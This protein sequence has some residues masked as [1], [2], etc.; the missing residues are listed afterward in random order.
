MKNNFAYL[1][2]DGEILNVIERLGFIEPT[3][4]QKKAI[5]YIF[6]GKDVVVTAATGSGK[7]LPY[8]IQ[9][10][11]K[12]VKGDGLQGLVLVPTREL[13]RQVGD[14]L[15]VFA[16]HKKLN[17]M[18]SYGG[19]SI[20]EQISNPKEVDILVGTP[21]RISDY[22]EQEIFQLGHLKIVVLDEV[23][24]MVQK[25]F[26]KEISYILETTPKKK[27]TIVL[28]ATISKEIFLLLKKIMYNPKLVSI[29]KE[30]LPKSLKHY[31]YLIESDKKLSLLS[32]LLQNERAGLSMIFANRQDTVDFLYN[33][34]KIKGIEIKMLYGDMSQ[35]KRNKIISDFENEKFDV[36]ICTDIVARGID[37]ANITHIYNYNISKFPE[38]YVHRAGRSA[39]ANSKG[40]VINLLSENDE[41]NFIEVLG[42]YDIY[43]NN[44]DLPEFEIVEV[45]SEYKAKRPKR[46][47]F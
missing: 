39:R 21:G 4:I 35:G 40:K 24:S 25:Q 44:M 6:A 29:Q 13:A 28:S 36:L 34:L 9:L 27:Q 3:K 2:I 20:K 14:L 41:K 37:I 7:T 5:P 12:C 1:E 15:K 47:S 26:L 42:K 22:V 8:I 19:G 32:H 46:K 38:K 10:V 43:V 31:S 11:K 23:D 17:I 18:V 16:E 30:D 33:N 45:R